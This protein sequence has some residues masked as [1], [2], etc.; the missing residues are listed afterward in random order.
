MVVV[1]SIYMQLIFAGIGF[2]FGAFVAGCVYQLG[3]CEV[4][5]CLLL[6]FF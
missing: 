6:L 2:P 3:T 1:F 4:H 5:H